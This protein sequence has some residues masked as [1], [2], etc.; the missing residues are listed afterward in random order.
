MF[1]LFKSVRGMIESELFPPK[2][3]QNELNSENM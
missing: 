1:W 2:P 3:K